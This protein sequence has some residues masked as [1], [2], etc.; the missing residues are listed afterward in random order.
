MLILSGCENKAKRF[1]DL[2]HLSSSRFFVRELPDKNGKIDFGY[3]E[4]GAKEIRYI[5]TFYPEEKSNSIDLY[6][7][8]NP[9]RIGFVSGSKSAIMPIT[10]PDDDVQFDTTFIGKEKGAFSEP[11][12]TL[13]VSQEWNGSERKKL[14]FM[15]YQRDQSY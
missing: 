4:D 3:Q 9:T 14:I 6:F 15:L 2:L 13:A 7:F 11:I 1:D 12:I 10:L 5:G 8:A